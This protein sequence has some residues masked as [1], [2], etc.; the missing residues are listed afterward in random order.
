MRVEQLTKSELYMLLGVALFLLKTFILIIGWFVRNMHK[1]GVGEI[2]GLRKDISQV[3]T[4]TEV[5]NTKI[6]HVVERQN[7]HSV[8]LKETQKDLDNHKNST[9]N[10]LKEIGGR[11]T[12]LELKSERSE[13]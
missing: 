11:V 7:I 1:E 5:H 13:S 6:D 2:K 10:E 8:D 3:I 4:K 12:R 9:L